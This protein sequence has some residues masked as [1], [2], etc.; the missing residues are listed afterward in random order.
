VE[1][2][3]FIAVVRKSRMD[4]IWMVSRRYTLVSGAF[5]RGNESSTGRP[6]GTTA[7]GM[8]LAIVRVGC[9]YDG[10]NL[11]DLLNEVLGTWAPLYG[12]LPFT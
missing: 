6:N 5:G 7:S 8:L 9:A 10:F 3:S 1:V 11:L 2:S 4:V 12:N